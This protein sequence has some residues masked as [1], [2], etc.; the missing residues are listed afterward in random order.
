MMYM[1]NNL[2][3]NFWNL[4][5]KMPTRTTLLLQKSTRFYDKTH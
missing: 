2:W 1:P 5:L 4:A 3:P